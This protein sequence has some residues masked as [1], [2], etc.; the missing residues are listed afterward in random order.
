MVNIKIKKLTESAVIPSRAT[1]N[2][3]G[4]DLVAISKTLVDEGDYGYIAYGTGLAIEIPS[5]YTGYIF[6]RSSISNT[7]HILANSVGVIDSDYRGEIYVR[8]K[9][10]PDS[11]EYEVGDRVCQLIILP[12]T[13]LEIE[14]VE[15][16]SSTE[17]GEGGFGST[18][19]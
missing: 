5:G 10:V 16:L 4:L 12:N 7:G 11:R 9:T 6:P 14:E 8:F 2:S 3:T 17:R 18:G 13:P 15:E 19:R 1:A